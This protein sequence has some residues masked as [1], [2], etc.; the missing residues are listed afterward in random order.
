MSTME[1]EVSETRPAAMSAATWLSTLAA[2]ALAIVAAVN[3]IFIVPAFVHVVRRTGKM[4][5]ASDLLLQSASI[6]E[7]LLIGGC[8]ALGLWSWRGGAEARRRV[9]L[10]LAFVNLMLVLYL[11]WLTAF[12][13]EAAVAIPP[14]R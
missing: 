10:S 9:D 5:Q 11:V 14:L 12:Y 6:A 7:W 8:V 3:M 1:T 13:I 2:F 4:S